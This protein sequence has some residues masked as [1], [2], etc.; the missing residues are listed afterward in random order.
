LR[1]QQHSIKKD[2]PLLKLWVKLENWPPFMKVWFR[3]G[4]KPAPNTIQSVLDS[5]SRTK[6]GISFIQVGANDGQTKDPI[7]KYV[8][9]DNWSG[10]VLEPQKKVFSEK[11]FPKLGKR[12]ELTLLNVAV[13]NKDEQRTLYK[14]SF[15]E[16][17]WATG[18]ASFLKENIVRRIQDG[19]VAKQAATEGIQIPATEAEMIAEEIV[20]CRSFNSLLDEYKM[21][22][23]DVLQIDTEG[24]DF[25]I[26]KMFPFTRIKPDVVSFET[27]HLSESDKTTCF[28]MLSDLGYKLLHEKCNS[29]AFLN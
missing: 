15:S 16:A 23:V 11:L 13:S 1:E 3:W 6:K 17:R 22:R 9:R 2:G 24:F 20:I 7:Y 8:I 28:K 5:Y 4:W 12:S 29:V 19:Y 25:E 21:P 27:E 26:I 10:L 18:L 14:I